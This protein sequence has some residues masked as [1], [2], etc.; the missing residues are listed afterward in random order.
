MAKIADTPTIVKLNNAAKRAHKN[1]YLSTEGVSR[2]DPDGTHVEFFSMVHNDVE[3][4]IGWLLKL[5]GRDEPFQAFIDMS[6]KDYNAL[7]DMSPE[8]ARPARE[9]AEA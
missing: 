9:A 6:F 1:R 7:E 5:V 8:E 4:R 2:L 3:L